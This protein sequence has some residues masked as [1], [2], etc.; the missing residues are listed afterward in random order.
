MEATIAFKC[1]ACKATFEFDPIGENE[2]VSCPLCGNDFRTV[3]M[4]K[5]LK[6]EPLGLD[7]PVS[8]DSNPPMPLFER[9]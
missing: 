6:L 8:L 7:E 5:T 1:P 3:K 2:F 4:G 9:N